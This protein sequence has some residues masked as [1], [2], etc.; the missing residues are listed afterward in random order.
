[1]YASLAFNLRIQFKL[2]K[3][4]IA[5][6]GLSGISIAFIQ[7]VVF[8]MLAGSTE[9]LMWLSSLYIL[10]EMRGYNK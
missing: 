2:W 10:N 9:P 7:S 4:M 6:I 1:M 3:A 5:L 8:A